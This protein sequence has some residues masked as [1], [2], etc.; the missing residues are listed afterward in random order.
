[1][2]TR[3]TQGFARREREALSDALL[4]AGPDAPTLC[5]G[6]AAKD[7]AAHIVLRERRPL[8]AAGILVKPLARRTA[9]IQDRIAAGDYTELV[10]K[11]RNPPAWSPVSNPVVHDKVNE[12]EMFVHHEDLRRAGAEWTPR[13][14]A[15]AD[16]ARLW[17]QIGR[18]AKL[19]LRKFPA[20][21]VLSAPGHGEKRAGGR[22]E[23]DTL[24]V[25]G[26]PGELL[27]FLT[28]RQQVAR[29]TVDGPEELA[30]KLRRARLGL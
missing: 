22:S 25:H 29:V 17:S 7:L 18:I 3:V 11:V 2:L 16:S 21:V 30:A 15:D 8:A 27:L 14:L 13:E 9:R 28:G 20:V 10:G 1:M 19:S 6:W 26:E 5:E 4:A 24:T 12:V 23:G